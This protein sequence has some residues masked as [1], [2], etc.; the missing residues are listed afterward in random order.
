MMLRCRIDSKAAKQQR[1]TKTA[2]NR[3][4]SGRLTKSERALIPRIRFDLAQRG[5]MPKRWELEV[6]ARVATVIYCDTK[7]RYV[8]PEY[9]NISHDPAVAG[10]CKF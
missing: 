6:L 7:S 10:V 1:A 4:L 8:D 5:I 3:T 2:G 9:V